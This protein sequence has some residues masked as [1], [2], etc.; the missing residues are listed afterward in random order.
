MQTTVKVL[1]EEGLH[2][3][4]A[5]LLVKLANNFSSVIELAVGENTANAKSIMSIMGLGLTKDT[6][7]IVTAVGSDAETALAEITNLFN[8][9]FNL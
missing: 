5:G 7:V 6:V 8:N 9:K 2:A 1:N 3:R 4:P